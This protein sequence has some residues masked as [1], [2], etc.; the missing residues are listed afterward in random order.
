MRFRE[1][2]TVYPRKMASGKVIWYYRTYDKNNRRTPSYSTGKLTKSAAKAY[3]Y[4]L[5]KKDKLV[6]HRGGNMTFKEYSKNWWIWDECEY[7][8]FRSKRKPITKSYADTALLMVNNKLIPVFGR[9]PLNRITTYDIEKWLDVFSQE[10]TSNA[11]ANLCL[12]VLKVMLKDAVR[13]KLIDVDPA[14]SVT[15]LQRNSKERGIPTPYEV[16]KL[17]NSKERDVIWKNRLYYIANLLAACTGMR[18]AEVVG[19][20]DENLKEGY[21]YLDK[22]YQPNYGLTD[23]KNHKPRDIVIPPLMQ[24]LLED[25]AEGNPEGFIFSTSRGKVPISSDSVRRS[26]EKAYEKIGITREEQKERSLCFHSWRH[27]LNTTLRSHN[28]TDGKL[29]TMVGHSGQGMTNHY[30]HFTAGDF[31]DIQKVQT[32]VFG[33][34]LA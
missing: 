25:L 14:S 11:S 13:R 26:L 19:L 4:D 32:E 17:F 9:I 34:H 30:T 33:R 22:Q 23:L 29:Q 5:Y 15:R 10:G 7:V 16:E 21:I 18:I 8:K 12:S 3:C 27:Y 31:E 28:I 2:F 1:P 24:K 20:R 6:P